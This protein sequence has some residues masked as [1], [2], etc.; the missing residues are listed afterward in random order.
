[1]NKGIIFSGNSTNS[2]RAFQSQK[3]VVRIMTGIK[4]RISHKPLSKALEILTLLSQHIP[5]SVTFLAHNLEYLTLNFSVHNIDTRKKVQVH[6]P[7][8][9]SASYQKGMYYVIIKICN[10]LP[11]STA[12]VVKHKKHFI[13]AL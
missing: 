5:S 2:K 12:K 13:L 9:N 4:S 1:M 8:A 7:I 10:K 6:R 11:A 3:K